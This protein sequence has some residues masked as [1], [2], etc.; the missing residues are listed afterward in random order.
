MGDSDDVKQ[1]LDLLAAGS[2][3]KAIRLL[4]SLGVMATTELD[5]QHQLRAK[6][7][8]RGATTRRSAHYKTYGI[9]TWSF[10]RIFEC[11]ASWTAV[12]LYL[13]PK[14]ELFGWA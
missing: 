2:F 13:P 7:P 3:R 1:L 12:T 5:V 8:Q 14:A 4:N 10:S 11:V 6:H 9:T